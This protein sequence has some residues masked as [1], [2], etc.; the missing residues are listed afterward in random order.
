MPV[1]D[2]GICCFLAKRRLTTPLTANS[3]KAV[4]ILL[5][6]VPACAVVR[7]RVGVVGDV[8]SQPRSRLGEPL[9]AEI[10]A[11]QGGDSLGYLL[12]TGQGLAD[13]AMPEPPLGPL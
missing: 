5:A 3:T 13:T 6:V 1:F 7:D 10:G 11:A 9:H 4:E 8:G 12:G 2:H